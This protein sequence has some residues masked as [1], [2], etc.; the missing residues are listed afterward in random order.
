MNIVNTI[1]TL[2]NKTTT[3][4]KNKSVGATSARNETD[5]EKHI[6]LE[7]LQHEIETLKGVE[8]SNFINKVYNFVI[9]VKIHQLQKELENFRIYFRNFIKESEIDTTKSTFL[10]IEEL[11]KRKKKI[12]E[13]KDT[14]T[15]KLFKIIMN[16][17]KTIIDDNLLTME[18][19]KNL[20]LF[21]NYE[22]DEY[23][24][25]IFLKFV[26]YGNSKGGWRTFN[27]YSLN[28]VNFNELIKI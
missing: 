23:Q 1:L 9:D 16:D 27:Y 11:E 15:V 18:K 19:I 13:I 3:D 26:K 12:D 2:Y 10:E 14:E 28:E 25:E 22:I 4:D 6:T 21:L 7:D 24:A 8:I 20:A 5:E 17:Y